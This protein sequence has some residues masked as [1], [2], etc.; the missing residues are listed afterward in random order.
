[1][2]A[3]SGLP[4]SDGRTLAITLSPTLM[5]AREP[6]V[7]VAMLGF[8]AD[9][10]LY[11]VLSDKEIVTDPACAATT[12]LPLSIETTSP[13]TRD[14]FGWPNTRVV[15]ERMN[16]MAI[17]CRSIFIKSKNIWGQ[18]GKKPI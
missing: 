11:S 14:A 16:A 1:V 2:R 12:I 17:V 18:T 8:S 3:A 7:A 6:T 4:L 15:R 9:M 13:E 5:S 10:C